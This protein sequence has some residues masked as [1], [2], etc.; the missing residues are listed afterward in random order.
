MLIEYLPITVTL[1]VAEIVPEAFCNVNVYF[2]ESDL[3]EFMMSRDVL[4]AVDAISIR[5]D[6]AGFPLIVH[7]TV[8]VGS[9]L[10]GTL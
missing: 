9:P 8:G 2:P 1:A 4:C 5:L 10:M 7:T 6:T 3:S